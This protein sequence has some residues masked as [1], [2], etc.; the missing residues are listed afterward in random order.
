[1]PF[2]SHLLRKPT[3][4]Q[5]F[6]GEQKKCLK[7]LFL[8]LF[9]ALWHFPRHRGDYRMPCKWTASRQMLSLPRGASDNKIVQLY[10]IVKMACS[11]PGDRRKE[12][13]CQARRNRCP[14]PYSILRKTGI[15]MLAARAYK[16]KYNVCPPPAPSNNVCLP[17]WP[18][19]K[20]ARKPWS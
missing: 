1:M 15:N 8:L 18:P 6:F 17:F 7:T 19:R 4:H 10:V 9:F 14:P 12:R 11:G 3:S 2:V 13:H 20:A 5:I 16:Y